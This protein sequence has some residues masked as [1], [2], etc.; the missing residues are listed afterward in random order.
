M[1]NIYSHFQSVALILLFL[2]S[3]CFNAEMGMVRSDTFKK[4]TQLLNLKVRYILFFFLLLGSLA[5]IRLHTYYICYLCN[6]GLDFVYLEICDIILTM[7]DNG[8]LWYLF[9][10]TYGFNTHSYV[11]FL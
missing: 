8:I 5:H 9:H 6:L 1:R 7:C 4:K 11:C 3:L 2:L 10:A